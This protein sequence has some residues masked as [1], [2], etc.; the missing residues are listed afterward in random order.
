[1]SAVPFALVLE[2]AGP[3]TSELLFIQAGVSPVLALL[4]ST[5]AAADDVV[6]VSAGCHVCRRPDGCVGDWRPAVPDASAILA[7]P[8]CLP[9]AQSK[10]RRAGFPS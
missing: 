3:S 6:A 7:L 5:L 1:M 10:G 4:A 2:E 9:P 8:V